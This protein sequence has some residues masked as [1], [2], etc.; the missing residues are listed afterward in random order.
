[1]NAIQSIV[2]NNLSSALI[3]EDDLDWDVRIKAQLS[4]FSRGVQALTQPLSG[5]GGYVDPTLETRAS[6]KDVT[7]LGYDLTPNSAPSTSEPQLSPYGDNWDV[8]WLGHCG[9][10]FPAPDQTIPK[11]RYLV[12]EDETVPS[13]R[14]RKTLHEEI[15]QQY[16][17]HDRII[18]H[19]MGPICTFAYAV[20][21]RGARRILQEI[22]LQSFHGP[23]DNLM[24]GFCDRHTCITSQPQYFNHWRA[25]GS[26]DRDSEINGFGNGQFRER[27]FSENVRF[28]VRL[29]IHR[30]LDGSKELE[31]QYPS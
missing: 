31:D 5:S 23:Y 8:L 2:S 24:A 30:L 12:S 1:M 20:S 7:P 18:H 21:Q 17:E 3:M 15:Q 4:D 11:G 13:F 29:N 25:P 28:S 26:G 10:R 27:G 6:A 22:G 9:V 16:K 14:H 19:A